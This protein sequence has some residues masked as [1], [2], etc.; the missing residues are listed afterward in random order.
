MVLANTVFPADIQKRIPTYPPVAHRNVLGSSSSFVKR[1]ATVIPVAGKPQA[2][3]LPGSEKPGFSAVYRNSEHPESLV[4]VI[5]PSI[6]TATDLFRCVVEKHPNAPCMGERFFDQKTK[7]WSPYSFQTY[8]EIDQRA[9]NLASGIINIVEKHTNLDPFREQ[10]T[11]GLYGPNSRNWVLTDFACSRTALTTVP[12]YD[13]LGQESIEYI[14][15]LTDMPIVFATIPHIPYL[16]SIKNILPKLKVIVSLND[17]TDPQYF[18]HPGHSKR[19]VLAEWAKSAGVELYS[20]SDVEESGKTTPR[21]HREPVA[22]DVF[23]INFTSGTT[24]NPKGVILRHSCV[25][26]AAS[27]CRMNDL[28]SD[29]VGEDAFLSFL[30]LAHVFERVNIHAMIG[31]GVYVGFFRGDFNLLF[32]DIKELQPTMI[33]GVP[34]IWN[35]MV[36][37]IRTSTTE[38]PGKIGEL[39]REAFKAKLENLKE[40]QEVTHPKYDELWTNNIRKMLGFSRAK[41][42]NSGSAPLAAEN[43]DF[44]KCALGVRFAEGYGLTETTSGMAVMNPRDNHSGA[45]GPPMITTEVCLRDL[46]ELGYSVNDKPYPRGEI[47]IR[48]P[49]LFQGYYKN[50]EETA[51]ALTEDGWFHTGDVGQIDD[52]GRLYIIDR[53]KNMFKLA[54]GEYVATER[55]ESIY[56]SASSLISQVFI[57]GNS[58]ET[59][60]VGIIGVTPEPFVH[61]LKSELNIDVSASDLS[62]IQSY[63][64]R[65]D[66]RKAVLKKLTKDVA[67]AGL[68]GFEKIQNVKLYIDPLSPENGTLTP[69]LKIKRPNC[70]RYFNPATTEMYQEGQLLGQ[71]SKM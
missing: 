50:P 61:L 20:F 63:F 51:K 43:I 2:I 56:S 69:T 14:V 39:S 37:S 54:Q 29:K 11:V 47:M 28:V 66:V 58:L 40:N 36:N 19:D 62:K 26:A 22:E 8:S 33:C 64:G 48:G 65:K 6:R 27:V 53:V 32:E 5:H 70:R 57:D 49:Q 10:Y 15:N 55:L 12:L 7:A 18:E 21:K 46:P 4:S 35:K 31:A 60:L 23:T 3:P 41:V 68:K 13:T 59:Y 24:G 52:I 42:M 30:P 9:S 34:R 45:V 17:L 71:R 1:I 67:P 25:A 38:A 44:I 16:L